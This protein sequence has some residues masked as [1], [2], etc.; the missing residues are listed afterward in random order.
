MRRNTEITFGIIL[1]VLVLAAVIV[2]PLDNGYLFKKPVQYGIDL[3]SGTEI[4]FKADLSQVPEADRTSAMNADVTSITQRVDVLG[5]TNPVIQR[6]GADRIRVQLPNITDIEKAKAVIGQTTILE[7]GELATD[8]NDTDIRPEW[9]NAYGNWKPA[10]GMLNG[11]KK[12]LTS[13]YFNQNTYVNTDNLGSLL[14]IFSWNSD[15]SVLSKEITTRLYNNKNA[16][17]GIFSGSSALKGDDG[18]PIAPR[19]N[20]I[21]TDRGEISGLSRA[22]ATQLSALL[23]LG[24]IPVPLSPEYSHVISPASGA[25][26]INLALKATV[27]ALILVIL[28]MCIYYKLPGVL[29]SLALIIYALV[30]LAIY[31]LLPVTLTLAGIGGFVASLGMAVD[32][33]ILIFERMKEELRAGRTVGAAIEA[34]FKR[35]WSAIWDCNFTTFIACGIMYWLGSSVEASSLVTGFA[36]TLFIGVALS[37]ITAITVTRTFLRMFI[38]TSLAQKTSL[39]TVIGG[40]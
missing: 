6:Q 29:A 15:G 8:D 26:F 32:A 14:L 13:A 31:K 2:F 24:R 35:A 3:K 12:A 37:M 21:I 18:Q 34:G 1:V 25:N 40:K 38:G 19:V 33:N 22:E 11:E 9:K 16:Q 5:V 28:F 39:F 4:V 20:G 36:L 7:F 23:N 27:I 10:Y 30:N 17:L